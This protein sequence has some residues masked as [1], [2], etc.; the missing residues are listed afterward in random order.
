MHEKKVNI[1]QTQVIQRIRQSLRHVV[2]VVLVVPQLGREEDLLARDA[3]L[4][5]CS[6]DCFFRS[7]PVVYSLIVYL[8]CGGYGKS[9][10]S[11]GVDVS[12][13]GL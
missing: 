13:S 2:R 8:D 5:N 12:V 4:F 7:I 10:H 9:I 6:A 1:F 3:G 11:R